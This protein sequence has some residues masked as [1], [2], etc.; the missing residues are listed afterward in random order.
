M[1]KVKRSFERSTWMNFLLLVFGF[2]TQR[3]N[4]RSI[5]SSCCYGYC[6]LHTFFHRSFEAYDANR[7]ELFR[8][9]TL[10]V[11]GSHMF[12]STRNSVFLVGRNFATDSWTMNNW[13]R[14]SSAY[15]HVSKETK[16][17]SFSSIYSPHRKRVPVD[18]TMI[19]FS[20]K[21][22]CWSHSSDSIS[23]FLLEQGTRIYYYEAFDMLEREQVIGNLRRSLTTLSR[24]PHLL[25]AVLIREI[26]PQI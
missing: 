11:P 7:W 14:P 12:Y 2:S 6:P 5:T 25:T 26:F 17:R 8:F 10:R 16:V 22:P 13:L 24:Y 15:Q 18:K 20:E 1:E 4:E 9:F 23:I 21:N 19:I 3:K